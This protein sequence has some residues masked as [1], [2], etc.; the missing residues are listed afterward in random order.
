MTK[1]EAI[2]RGRELARKNLE[3]RYLVREGGDRYHA[4]E[5]DTTN[6]Y[7][8]ETFWQGATPLLAIG[9]NGDIE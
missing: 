7:G 1:A 8:L 6:D 2:R 5:Y 4:A 3:W 9:P